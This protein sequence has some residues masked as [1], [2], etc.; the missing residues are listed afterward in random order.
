MCE[1]ELVAPI[2]ANEI[3]TPFYLCSGQEAIVAGVCAALQPEEYVF[4]N[5]RSHGHYLAKGG[6]LRQLVAE[7]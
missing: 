1:E 5:H 3:L 4:G 7:V 2:V 6:S